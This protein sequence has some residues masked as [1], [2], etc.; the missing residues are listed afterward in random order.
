SPLANS[1][2][3]TGGRGWP[4]RRRCASSLTAPRIA[5]T[6]HAADTRIHGRTRR[7]G[8]PHAIVAHGAAQWDDRSRQPARRSRI[9]SCIRDVRGGSST[10][11]KPILLAFALALAADDR[12][13]DVAAIRTHIESIFQAFIDKDVR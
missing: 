11:M 6:I 8:T 3:G 7:R 2:S 5:G 1:S 10:A 4:L 9:R 12:A 13:A